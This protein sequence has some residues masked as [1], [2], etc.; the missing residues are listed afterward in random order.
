VSNTAISLKS[1]PDL[2]LRTLARGLKWREPDLIAFMNF[3]TYL[4][5]TGSEDAKIYE[6]LY[7]GVGGGIAPLSYWEQAEMLWNVSLADAGLDVFHVKSF[8]NFE[9]DHPEKAAILI[10]KLSSIVKAYVSPIGAFGDLQAYRKVRDSKGWQAYRGLDFATQ[11]CFERLAS[12]VMDHDRVNVIFAKTPK[13]NGRVVEIFEAVQEQH[14]YGYRLL[15]IVPNKVP[16]TEKRLQLADFV[17]S[18]FMR[19]WNHRHSTGEWHDDFLFHLYQTSLNAGDW[20]YFSGVD[21]KNY[22]PIVD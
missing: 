10:D 7:I 18:G 21:L 13:Y 15:D 17:I 1:E 19:G 12:R 16:S 8:K 5:D 6:C 14:P 4:D 20:K 9:R 11:W 3:W 2:Y 22:T